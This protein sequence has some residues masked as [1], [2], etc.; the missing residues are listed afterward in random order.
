MT[1]PDGWF[2]HKIQDVG[3]SHDGNKCYKFFLNGQDHLPWYDSFQYC[4][5]I[6]ARSLHIETPAEAKILSNYF[7]EWAQGGVTR[8]WIEVSDLGTEKP[9]DSC[10]FTYPDSSRPP[11]WTNWADGS[12]M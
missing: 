1:C 12:S 3:N 6:G 5:S 2:F 8:M 7:H 4:K 9:S 11:D 10:Q